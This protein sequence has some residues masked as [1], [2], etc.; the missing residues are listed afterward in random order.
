MLTAQLDTPA[1]KSV[2]PPLCVD[3]DGTLIAGDLLWE[4][5]LALLRQRPWWL[6]LLPVWL[7]RGK[8]HL[9]EQLACRVHL[10]VEALPYRP[11]VLDLI[12]RAKAAGRR[13]VLATASNY[14]FAMAV[15]DY[16]QLFDEVL[17]SDSTHNLKGQAKLAAVQDRCTGQ[18]FDYVGD[19][20][21]DLP[22]WAAAR[23]AYVVH[24]SRRLLEKAQAVCRGAGRP[25][26]SQHPWEQRTAPGRGACSGCFGRTSGPRTCCFSSLCSPLTR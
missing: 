1:P 6:L 22:L 11:E 7:L 25:A 17:A 19:S 12:R 5:L 13:I 23:Q 14:R 20:E 4:A 16:L 10:A 15:A 24:P 18:R 26:A 2:E 3:L 9:K 21:A 8:S